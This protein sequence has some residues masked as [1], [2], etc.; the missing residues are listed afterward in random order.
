MVGDLR[1]ISSTHSAPTAKG[2]KTSIHA[3]H[4]N[5]I[6]QPAG[7]NISRTH[8]PC[9]EPLSSSDCLSA[10]ESHLQAPSRQQQRWPQE[11]LPQRLYAQNLHWPP[12]F[13]DNR[14]SSRSMP[15]GAAHAKPS[16]Q[17]WNHSVEKKAKG[18]IGSDLMSQTAPIPSCPRLKQRNLDCRSSIRTIAAKQAW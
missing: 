1:D 9:Q 3:S 12:R 6:R 14:L 16:S 5:P 18:C 4:L 17:F 7:M 15:R 10:Q 2:S 13:R 11:R 8:W